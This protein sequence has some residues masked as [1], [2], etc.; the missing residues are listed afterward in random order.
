MRYV[1]FL[2]EPRYPLRTIVD[3]NHSRYT[4]IHLRN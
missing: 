4:E 2:G 1:F 3:T